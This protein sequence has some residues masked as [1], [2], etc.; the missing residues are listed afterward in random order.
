MA[1][2]SGSDP[3]ANTALAFE[4][5]GL[6]RLRWCHVPATSPTTV[7]LAPFSRISVGLSTSLTHTEIPKSTISRS[8]PPI[9][10]Y[11]PSTIDTARA[12]AATGSM[13]NGV[14]PTLGSWTPQVTTER[15]SAATTI[16]TMVSA[17]RAREGV[18]TEKA[19]PARSDAEGTPGITLG[20]TGARAKANS[21]AANPRQAKRKTE[22]PDKTPP[23]AKPDPTSANTSA[24]HHIRRRCARSCAR[25]C[26]E[27]IGAI[28]SH[29]AADE[30]LPGTGLAA[31]TAENPL[32]T[33]G[34][35]CGPGWD[36]TSD[37]P[38]VNGTLFH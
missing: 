38:G 19:P 20:R 31:H 35:R 12:S 13:K 16:G 8:R 36:R 30:P 23:A 14:S 6:E 4:T 34:S 15:N 18:T 3:S 32:R 21:K 25:H 28:E 11:R 37:L 17:E 24:H 33:G 26:P 1:T 27:F 10:T 9:T 2:A 7:S 5:G 29:R 22:S